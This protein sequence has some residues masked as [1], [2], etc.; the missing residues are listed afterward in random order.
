MPL[1]N[2]S[3]E[4]VN[5]T[6]KKRTMAAPK[7]L[8]KDRGLYRLVS[9][10]AGSGEVR[11]RKRTSATTVTPMLVSTNRKQLHHPGRS[12]IFPSSESGALRL[13]L[14]KDT[15][16]GNNEKPEEVQSLREAAASTAAKAV[17]TLIGGTRVHPFLAKYRFC[18]KVIITDRRVLLTFTACSPQNT[19][20]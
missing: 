4:K 19:H 1:T 2:L 3:T 6:P 20:T 14:L 15:I 11:L 17:F 9:S 16:T 18:P 12:V 7:R 5:R 8:L 10:G 13:P